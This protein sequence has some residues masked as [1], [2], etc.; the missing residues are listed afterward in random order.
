MKCE[1][2]KIE[3][4]DDASITKRLKVQG[5]WLVVNCSTSTEYF[6]DKKT[7]QS[8]SFLPDPNHKWSVSNK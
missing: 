2:E 6:W 7:S 4:F 5:G 8:M 1:W 3:S